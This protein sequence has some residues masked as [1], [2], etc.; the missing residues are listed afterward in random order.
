VEKKKE[1]ELKGKKKGKSGDGKDDSESGEKRNKKGDSSEVSA[2]KVLKGTEKLDGD[3][4]KP[5]V[6][7]NVESANNSLIRNSV[8]NSNNISTNLNNSK[9]SLLSDSPL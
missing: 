9:N 3:M 8:L 4:K 7:G 5:M 1:D 2:Q 6:V